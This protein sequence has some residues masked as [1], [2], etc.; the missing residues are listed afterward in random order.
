MTGSIRISESH[1]IKAAMNWSYSSRLTMIYL[2]GPI[3][4]LVG[5]TAVW[6]QQNPDGRLPLGNFDDP[7]VFLLRDEEMHHELRLTASQRKALEKMSDEADQL[8]WPARNQSA[9]R[10]AA[11]WTGATEL[12]RKRGSEILTGPQ[13]QRVQQVILWIQG[14]RSLLR[15]DVA[16]SLKLSRTQREAIKKSAESSL[17]EIEELRKKAQ[18]GEPADVLEKQASKILEDE[19]QLILKQLSEAQKRDWLAL[20]GPRIDT[21]RLGKVSFWAPELLVES[22]EWLN[23]SSS[24]PSLDGK[25]AVV[26]FFANG[27]INC[28]RNYE[29]YRGWDDS[30]RGQDLVIVG[31]HTPETEAERDIERLRRKVTEAKFQFPILTDNEKKNWNAWGNSM[32]PSV[33]LVDHQGRIRYWWYG[34][35]SWQGADG[36]QRMRQRITELLADARRAKSAVR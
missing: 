27:C 18:S 13:W 9:E 2:L 14:T 32:W 31:I 35:L 16:E 33:Y 8:I 26:H 29:H 28:I 19:Q 6:S 3:L 30:F 21:S 17:R 23:T 10:V 4:L 15:D 25:V 20:L 24:P 11:A 7:I 36:E 12:A 34:E 22:E 1:V 5:S